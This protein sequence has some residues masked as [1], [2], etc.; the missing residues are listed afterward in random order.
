MG[1][2]VIANAV[3]SLAGKSMLTPNMA[4]SPTLYVK[5]HGS[6]EVSA[7]TL[8]YTLHTTILVP[9]PFIAVRFHL[10]NPSSAPVANVLAACAV[11]ANMTGGVQAPTG[12]PANLQVAGSNTITKPAALSG[13]S[14]ND[15]VFSDTITD[16]LY[17]PSVAR[18]DGGKGHLL[19]FR[20]YQ[21]AAGNTE[22]GRSSGLGN[23]IADVNNFGIACLAQNA[24]KV[25]SWGSWT[26]TVQQIGSCFGVELL[27][28]NGIIS[29]M[30]FGDSTIAG[31]GSTRNNAS[32]A[33]LAGIA[34]LANANPVGIWNY[35]EGLA[36]TSSYFKLFQN[37]VAGG[38]VPA[39]MA[40]C[41]FSPNDVDK[42]TRAGTDRQLLLMY[43]FVKT[44]KDN[45]IVPILVTPC[46]ESGITAPQEAFRR[47]VAAAAVSLCNSLRLICIDRDAYYTNYTVSTGGFNA[48]L[49]ADTKHPSL[50]GYTGESL[51]WLK[52]MD[53][54]R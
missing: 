37:M 33:V 43:Q 27:T 53:N 48:G 25:T 42:Y 45:N 11:S 1:A 34:S 47:E 51:L 36:Q 44:C 22:A 2:T 18:S 52:A 40:Y 14:G 24:D 10:F 50:A 23:T 28:A 26:T 5:P 46:P 9:V 39:A 3:S 6:F 7:G 8:G 41:P 16:W 31:T 38:A 32:G 12:T 13:G 19:M 15:A 20:E 54:L 49:N 35:G 30:S 4:N 17:M 29:I 21:P